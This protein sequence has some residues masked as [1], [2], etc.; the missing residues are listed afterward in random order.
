MSGFYSTRVEGSGPKDARIAIIGEGPGKEEEKW[1][2][3]FIGPAGDELNTLLSAAGIERRQCY[4][5]N[6]TK[7]R[8]HGDKRSAM[9]KGGLPSPELAE[10]IIDIVHY[11][12]EYKPEI[13]IACGQWALYGL[14]THGISKGD[15]IGTWRGSILESYLA[16]GQK[17]IPIYHPAF[18]LRGGGWKWRSLTIWDL[19]KAKREADNPQPLPEYDYEVVDESGLS[20]AYAEITSAEWIV[21]DIELF[22]DDELACIGFG[23]SPTRCLVVPHTGDAT[24]EFYKSVLESSIPKANQNLMF[25]ITWLYNFL[26][27]KTRNCSWDTMTAAKTLYPTYPRSLAFL[28]SVY[29]RQPYYKEDGK[30][31]RKTWDLDLLWKYNATDCCVTYEIREA[32]EKDLKHFDIEHVARLGHDLIDPYAEST[33]IGMNVDLETLDQMN[34]DATKKIDEL[35]AQ[36]DKAIGRTI[37]VNSPPQVKEVV[38]GDLRLPKRY[39]HKKL[40]TR[41]EVLLDLA[42][43]TNNPILIGIVHL[44]ELMKFRGSFCT[45]KIIDKDNRLRCH[46]NVFGT[47][48]G[49]PSATKTLWKSGANMLTFPEKVGPDK[50]LNARRFVIPDPGYTFVVCDLMQAEAVVVAF[51]SEDELEMGWFHEELDSHLMLAALLSNVDPEDV[52]YEQRLMAKKC[53]H[54]L[55]YMMGRDT[56]VLSVNKDYRSTGVS[57]IAS[58]AS[59]LKGHYEALRPSLSKWWTDVGGQ[60][61][62]DGYIDTLMNRRRYFVERW[63]DELKRDAISYNPQSTVGDIGHTGVRKY[64]KDEEMID[65]RADKAITMLNETYDSILW[66]VKDELVDQLTPKLMRFLVTEL[67]AH[68]R[69]F[70]IPVEAKVGK[71]WSKESLSDFGV[72]RQ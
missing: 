61:R 52:T 47:K 64:W 30:K 6:I 8:P 57:I 51:L 68:D 20:K 23:I 71:R 28:T 16:P 33:N 46:V 41:K 72:L 27:I 70:I 25:D 12:R 9:L 65:L 49:R 7:Y 39:K 63:S 19:Q 3:P 21:P 43:K 18:L 4:V 32:Q 53:H 42:A 60:V 34:D 1:G 58:E 50:T 62:R 45:R 66:Q 54:A 11:L 5:D 56:F 40:T 36:L 44:R 15:L 35:Q 69:K 59:T 2:A 48:T 17:V 37:N 10:G 38:Y 22:A 14:T 13:V 26:G 24:K 55:N 29:T 31:W 67:E